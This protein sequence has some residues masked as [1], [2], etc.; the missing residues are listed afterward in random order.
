MLSCYSTSSTVIINTSLSPNSFLAF[1]VVVSQAHLTCGNQSLQIALFAV[2][3]QSRRIRVIRG[4]CRK[5][6]GRRT[7]AFRKEGRRERG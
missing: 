6:A 3:T 2:N 5:N 1:H 4:D 7:P